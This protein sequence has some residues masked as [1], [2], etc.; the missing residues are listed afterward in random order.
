MVGPMRAPRHVRDAYVHAPHMRAL[1]GTNV[2]VR[3]GP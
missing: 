1:E 3:G 2:K